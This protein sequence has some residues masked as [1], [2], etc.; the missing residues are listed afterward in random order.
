MDGAFHAF[1][2]LSQCVFLYVFRELGVA[3]PNAAIEAVPPKIIGAVESLWFKL[4]EK[5]ILH[6]H[7]KMAGSF[8]VSLRDDAKIPSVLIT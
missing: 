3:Y 5:L 2:A 7:L 1:V 6:S 4:S 8:E